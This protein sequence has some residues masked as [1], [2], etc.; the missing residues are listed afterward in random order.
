MS[1]NTVAKPVGNLADEIRQSCRVFHP[2]TIK[3]VCGKHGPV[4]V[5]HADN[6]DRSPEC[7]LCAEER[8]KE[9]ETARLERQRLERLTFLGIRDRH[10]GACFG[11]YQSANEKAAAHTRALFDIAQNPRNTTVLLYGKSGTGKTHLMSAA[12]I[13][14]RGVYT[15]YEFLSME[16]R[17]S[18]SPA[19]KKTE[20]ELVKQYCSM[21]FLA[22]DEIEKGKNEDAKRSLLSLICRERHERNL[23]LW[24]AGNCNYEWLKA[25]LDS[26]VLDRL[27]ASGK[28][29]EFDWES[30][31]PKL[32]ETKNS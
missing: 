26:S 21:P 9:A 22:I 8:A 6:A 30:Y 23:P 18:Y 31:R 17:A 13:L 16:I 28:S 32:R 12:V 15:T 5:V 25:V 29:F 19:S 14:N 24:L 10:L 2:N 27:A 11:N 20:Y 3:I 1:V 4:D 7:P